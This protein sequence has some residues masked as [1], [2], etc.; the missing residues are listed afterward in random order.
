MRISAEID[1]Q[2][3]ELKFRVQPRPHD[4]LLVQS[5]GL[6]ELNLQ[7]FSW[8][9]DKQVWQWLPSAV[10]LEDHAVSARTRHFSLFQAGGKRRKQEQ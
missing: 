3:L 4:P 8:N 5:Q 1:H 2:S 10:N 7:V 6:S 9:P